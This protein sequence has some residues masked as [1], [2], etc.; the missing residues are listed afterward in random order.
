MCGAF[1]P[2]VKSTVPFFKAC[3]SGLSSATPS[4]VPALLALEKQ[5]LEKKT[6]GRAPRG[7][8]TNT[9]SSSQDPDNL[10]KGNKHPQLFTGCS[11]NL[12]KGNKQLQLFTGPWD[13]QV[14]SGVSAELWICLLLAVKGAK[15]LLFKVSLH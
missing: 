4:E 1:H 3:L 7:G 12:R 14:T 9:P 6:P 10:R 2:V 8:G 13:A 5:H 15:L 11:G